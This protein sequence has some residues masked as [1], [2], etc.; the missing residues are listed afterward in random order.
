M[1][2]IPDTGED[3]TRHKIPHIGWQ[4]IIP[5]D[6]ERTRNDTIFFEIETPIFVYFVHSYS[7]VPAEK[8]DRLADTDYNGHRITAAVRRENI[9]GCQF[10][11]E[12]SGPTGLAMLRNFLRRK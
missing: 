12:R 7:A 11:P 6:E 5:P 9:W 4:E 2:K 3:G 1:I 8:R 10:H